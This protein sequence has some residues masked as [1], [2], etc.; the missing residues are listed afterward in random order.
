M[1][2]GSAARAL[3]SAALLILPAVLAGSVAGSAHALP[4]DP[5][6]QSDPAGLTLSW[7]TLGLSSKV[8]L[9]P[10]S[11]A[12]FSVPVPEGLSA[13]RLQG[14]FHLP[15]NIGA[16]YLEIDD[17]DGRLLASVDLPPQ[18]PPKS[19]RRSTSTSRRP[20]FEQRRSTCPSP[21]GRSTAATN[22][23]VHCS[24]STSAI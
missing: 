23:A 22:F 8:T 14:V 19:S 7:P 16:G 18:P 20:V 4:G 9:G 12:K 3:I 13:T 1:N 15:M 21:S 10:N 2:R 17:G 6:G 5:A 24:S 11:S